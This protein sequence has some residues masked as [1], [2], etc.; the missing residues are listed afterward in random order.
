MLVGKKLWIQV[1]CSGSNASYLFPWELQQIKRAGQ[2]YLI[3]KITIY[4]ILFFNI[5]ITISYALLPAMNKSLHDVLVKICT[6]GGDP[7]FH[8]CYD[9]TLARKMLPMQCVLHQTE[10][11]EVR[12]GQIWNIWCLWY[13]SPDKIGNVFHGFQISTVPSII[14]LEEKGCLLFRHDF[15]TSGLQLIWHHD[16]A[17][18]VEGLSRSQEISRIAPFLFHNTVHITFSLIGSIFDS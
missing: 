9:N 7:L 6:S 1:C 2:H 18:R 11:M 12:M 3:K 17:V 8:K 16:E 4:K 5:V 14:M 13:N 15:G 10:Q